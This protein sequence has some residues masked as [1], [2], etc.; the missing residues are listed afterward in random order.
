MITKGEIWQLMKWTLLWVG[1]WFVAYNLREI[2]ASYFPTPE[3]QILF[4][5]GVLLFVAYFW[6]IR[7]YNGRG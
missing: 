7:R 1:S 2:I 5:V 6:D 4:G 3:K